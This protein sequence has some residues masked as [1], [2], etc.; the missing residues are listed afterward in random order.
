MLTRISGRR[1]WWALRLLV[2]YCL[3]DDATKREL[4]ERIDFMLARH[5][6]REAWA[7]RL[8]AARKP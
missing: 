1:L 8:E 6:R 7:A 2:A 5:R 4:S 3:A